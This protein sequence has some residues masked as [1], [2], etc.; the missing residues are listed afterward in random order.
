MAKEITENQTEKTKREL[1]RERLSSRYPD[2]NMD[3]ED[4]VYGKIN[5]DY[6][7]YDQSR[8]NEKRLIDLFDTDARA[9]AVFDRWAKGEHPI[10]AALD[11]YG[12]DFREA[13][14]DPEMK[15]AF[16]ESIRKWNEEKAENEAALSKAGESAKASIEAF[17]KVAKS[18][19]YDD[20][21][22]NAV[23]ELY[24][25]I[26]ESGSSGVVDEATWQALF[27]AVNYDIDVTEAGNKGRVEGRNENIKEKLRK[28]STDGL[29]NIKPQMGA[30]IRP[31]EK[32]NLGNALSRYS[33]NNRDIWER[34][35]R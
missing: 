18:K 34:G 30:G 20:A 12:P 15:D 33:D 24:E 9:A 11:E 3:D 21:K 26:V 22:M 29:P 28:S 16:E 1:L 25:R 27:N 7:D 4:A 19:G 5:E 13:I 2:M 31:A 32:R 8:E 14:L 10:V 6:D 35:K 23:F 17:D